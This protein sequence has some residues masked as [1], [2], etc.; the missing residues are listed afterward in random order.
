MSRAETSAPD[1][2]ASDS[3]ERPFP[4]ARRYRRRVLPIMA[5]FVVS[6]VALTAFSVRQAVRE[7]H[8]EF[9]ARGV[10]EIAAEVDAK[11]PAAWAALLAGSADAEQRAEL[12]APFAEAVSERGLIQL[13]VYDRNGEAV[14][15]TDA[16]DIGKIESNE[17]LTSAIQEGERTLLPHEEADGTRYNEFYVPILRPDGAVGL[18]MELYWPA[19]ELRAILARAL[20]L[21][22]LV[23]GLLLLGLLVVLGYLIR[24]AQAGIDFR[25]QRVREL[26]ARLESFMSSSAVGAVRAA[27]TGSDMPLMRIEVSL[28]YSDVRRF[29]DFSETETP[30]AVVAFLNRI[31]TLQIECVT[32]HGGDVDKLIGDAI[33]ARFEGEGKEARAVRAALDIQAAVEAAGLPR[34]VGVG[35]FTGPAISG[36]IGPEA[37]RDYT[38]VGDSVNIAARLCSAARRGE[39][40]ADAGTL[41]R[42]GAAEGFGPAEAIK[43]KGRE[44]AVEVRRWAAG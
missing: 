29:T 11:V 14:F 25:A 31:M 5:L 21:P 43:V 23:P 13:K 44:H 2:A 7:I 20:V 30:E 16:A 17:A 24:R 19:G 36:P 35:V 42:S 3:A 15:S 12:A 40:V 9:A 10:D 41:T 32:R 26:S 33:L 27:P 34:G 1:I 8:L 37:R 38:V 22:T 39:I 28:V 4:L 6:L 18:V